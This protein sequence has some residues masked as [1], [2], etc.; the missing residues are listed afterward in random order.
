[1][2]R[3]NTNEMEHRTTARVPLRTCVVTTVATPR[4]HEGGRKTTNAS[5]IGWRTKA[6]GGMQVMRGVEAWEHNLR[7]NERCLRIRG[8][9]D[10]R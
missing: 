2:Y 8:S 1:M 6:V 4:T 10:L 7:G 9:A 5:N 3:N